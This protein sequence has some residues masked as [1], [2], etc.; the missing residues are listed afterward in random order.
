MLS[1]ILILSSYILHQIVVKCLEYDF[2]M[3]RCIAHILW[4]FLLRFFLY[5]SSA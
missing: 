3:Q 4:K 5:F 2:K 1:Q